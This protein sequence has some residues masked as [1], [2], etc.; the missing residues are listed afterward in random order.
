MP[1]LGMPLAVALGVVFEET[2]MMR[3]SLRALL[4]ASVVLCVHL[5]GCAISDPFGEMKGAPATPSSVYSAPKEQ[6][7]EPSVKGTVQWHS[8]EPLSLAEC[9]EIALKN[10]PA[11]S[12]SWQRTRA[13][14]AAVGEARSLYM[15]QV[16]FQANAQRQKAQVLTEVEGVFL[17]TV[18]NASFGVR[19]LL[20]DG[21]VRRARVSAAEEVLRGVGLHHNAALL[22]VALNTEAAYY[23]L[24]AARSL[25]E[26]AQDALRQRERH[27]EF[28]QALREAGLGRLVDVMQVKA[29]KADAVLAVVEA[30]NLVRV[31]RGRLASAMGLPAWTHVE[32]LDIPAAVQPAVRDDV[33]KLLADGTVNR[34]RLRAALAEVAA[35]RH[36][37]RAEKAARLPEVKLSADYGWTDVHMLPEERHEW[38]IGLGLSVPIFTGFQRTYAIRR[39]EAELKAAI[40]D[41]QK[42]LRDAELEIWEA[43][44]A[45]V[46]AEEALEAAEAYEESSRESLTVIE[47]EYREGRATI[48]ELIDAQTAHTRARSRGVRATLNWYLAIARLERAVGRASNGAV[49]TGPGELTPPAGGPE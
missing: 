13:A 18:H 37:L 49:G 35:L 26:V 6:P 16:T 21:G 25:L 30:R 42:L 19:Q 20:L 8:E 39:T 36:Q 28:A 5:A 32:I 47:R 22:D 45:L 29:E 3:S 9:I 2:E 41:Y 17:R 14:A 31:G 12:S 27:L 33:E 38:D 48:V 11:L 43:Y 40:A 34:P 7:P 44:S 46:E 23:E 10:S 4:N 24:L 15:P 1:H